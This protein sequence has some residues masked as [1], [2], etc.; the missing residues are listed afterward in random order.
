[1]ANHSS[2]NAAALTVHDVQTLQTDRDVKDYV[3]Q[4]L[5]QQW[6]RRQRT[7]FGA[8]SNNK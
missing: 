5:L 1:M 2:Y 7:Q 4:Q 3:R 8:S 6:N